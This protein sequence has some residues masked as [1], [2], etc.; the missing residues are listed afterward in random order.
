MSDFTADSVDFLESFSELWSYITLYTVAG[1][2]AV[3]FGAG[4]RACRVLEYRRSRWSTYIWVPLATASL[5]AVLGFI[6]GALSALVLSALYV[7]IP[8]AIGTD[9]AAGLGI[10]QAAIVT[11][12][13]G[14]LVLVGQRL[15]L[16][17]FFLLSFH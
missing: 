6:S 15:S 7:S 14:Q 9:V 4:V 8:Y 16:S 2:A 3:Y 12:L 11:Y 10:G 1:C 17:L 5:G 13:V